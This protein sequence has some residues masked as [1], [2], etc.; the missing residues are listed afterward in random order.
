MVASEGCDA[1]WS[2]SILRY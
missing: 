2:Q 1:E